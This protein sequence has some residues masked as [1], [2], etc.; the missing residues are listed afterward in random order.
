MTNQFF[1]L[2][3]RKAHIRLKENLKSV[4][5]FPA[6]VLHDTLTMQTSAISFWVCFYRYWSITKAMKIHCIFR[7]RLRTI[8]VR[9]VWLQF[10]TQWK[11]NCLVQQRYTF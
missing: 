5:Y 4:S 1:S 6:K 3:Y 2:I 10:T 11:I 8:R 9:A 7:S